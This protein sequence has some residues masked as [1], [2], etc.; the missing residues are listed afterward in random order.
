RFLEVV[1]MEKGGAY[2]Y[3]YGSADEEDRD[4]WY[5]EKCG[6]EEKTPA[7]VMHIERLRRGAICSNQLV[8]P[9]SAISPLR[10]DSQGEEEGGAIWLVGDDLLGGEKKEKQ[11]KKENRV[12]ARGGRR[13]EEEEG[14]GPIRRLGSLPV[15]PLLPFQEGSTTANNVQPPPPPPVAGVVAAPAAVETVVV[16]GNSGASDAVARGRSEEIGGTVGGGGGDIGFVDVSKGRKRKAVK[17]NPREEGASSSESQRRKKAEEPL[18]R[19][20]ITPIAGNP[21]HRTNPASLTPVPAPAP[22]PIPLSAPPYS[23]RNGGE[24]EPL[25]FAHPYSLAYSYLN[26]MSAPSSVSSSSHH[27]LD[28]GANPNADGRRRRLPQE[29][30]FVRPAGDRRQ[31]QQHSVPNSS[32]HLPLMASAYPTP[33]SVNDASQEAIRSTSPRQNGRQRGAVPPQGHLL[34]TS[35]IPSSAITATPTPLANPTNTGD[36]RRH[37]Y[38]A[39]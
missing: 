9:A 25:I 19:E 16:V 10:S 24:D 11:T 29:S 39:Q 18:G 21:T 4:S 28:S 34:S 17:V 22:A 23:S 15:L 2:G 36:L 8:P 5:D 31:Q 1:E 30:D 26:T 20:L 35:A 7:S 14:T 38:A 32:R 3:E 33:R 12:Q 13:Q 6:D 27:V 37:P